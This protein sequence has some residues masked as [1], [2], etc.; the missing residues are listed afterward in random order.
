MFG[1]ASGVDGAAQSFRAD[2]HACEAAYS[3]GG[4]RAEALAIV[5]LVETPAGQ[6]KQEKSG[7]PARQRHGSEV[8]STGHA[9]GGVPRP[10]VDS[11]PRGRYFS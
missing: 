6:Q 1:I 7:R 4:G 10:S 5:E 3:V 2:A 9:G 8:H 11:S